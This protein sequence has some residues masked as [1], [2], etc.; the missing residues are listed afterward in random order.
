MVG[1]VLNE[2]VRGLQT[3]QRDIVRAANEIARANVRP[4]AT[5]PETERD[6]STPLQP[7]EETAQTERRQ[8]ISEPLIEL[9]RQEVLFNASA[10]VVATADQALGS[11]LDTEA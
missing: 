7:V 10:E 11:I 8:D 5:S 3:S 2:G 6:V 1:S 4:E 9:R